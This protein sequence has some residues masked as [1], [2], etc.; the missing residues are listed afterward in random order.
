MDINNWKKK[1]ISYK[2][3]V[4]RLQDTLFLERLAGSVG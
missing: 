2:Y 1:I 3:D 4:N